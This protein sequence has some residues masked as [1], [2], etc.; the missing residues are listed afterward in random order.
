MDYSYLNQGFDATCALPPSM[1]CQIACPPYSDPLT[2]ASGCATLPVGYGRYAAAA[3]AASPMNRPGN[4]SSNTMIDAA[5][6]RMSRDTMFQSGIGLQ[7]EFFQHLVQL[8]L[9]FFISTDFP[10]KMPMGQASNHSS[11]SPGNTVVSQDVTEKRKQ[12]RIRTT[13][14][15]SQ[16]KELE[17]AF[18]ET[19]Y[20]DIYTREEIALRTDLTEARVQVSF[21]STYF[22]FLISVSVF[23]A[24]F[25]LTFSCLI[26]KFCFDRGEIRK[27][28]E[29]LS[30]ES[31]PRVDV[32]FELTRAHSK[33]SKS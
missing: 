23:C 1:D 24:L 14:S 19:H 11:V 6:S 32:M 7:S 30:R 3:V 22:Y 17:K 12:R 15:S 20:P 31:R 5:V 26:V 4:A 21:T 27:K 13:F 16:L 29:C 33:G 18:Q 9:I 2:S 25:C 28:S 8:F 10:Y